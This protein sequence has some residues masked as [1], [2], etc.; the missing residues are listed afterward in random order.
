MSKSAIGSLRSWHGDRHGIY[1]LRAGSLL[2][3]SNAHHEGWLPGS[4][5]VPA[6]NCSFRSPAS[7][8]R[9]PWQSHGP[10]LG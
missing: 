8:T 6:R 7:N 2:G 4:A 3:L 5:Y 10:V 9:G 1:Q